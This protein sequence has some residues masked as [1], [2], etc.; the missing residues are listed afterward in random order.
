MD[1]TIWTALIVSWLAVLAASVLL[2]VRSLQ[3]WRALKRLRRHLGRELKGLANTLELATHAVD[4][5]TDTRRLD[6][7]LERLRVGLARLAILRDAFEEAT[8]SVDR[9]ASVYPRK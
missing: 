6:R 2:T 7:S 8:E 9:I 4:R 3:G 1:W 5:A